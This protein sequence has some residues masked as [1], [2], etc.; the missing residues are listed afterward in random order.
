[1]ISRSLKHIFI[2]LRQGLG[3]TLRERKDVNLAPFTLGRFPYQRLK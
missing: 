2:G 3:Y 1:M